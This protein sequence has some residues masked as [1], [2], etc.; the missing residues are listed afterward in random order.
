MVDKTTVVATDKGRTTLDTVVV[1]ATPQP[2]NTA[3]SVPP[4]ASKSGGMGPTNP[5]MWQILGGAVLGVIVL[6]ILA[7]IY[8]AI[9]RRSHSI[10]ANEERLEEQHQQRVMTNMM[11]NNSW[12]S[13]STDHF[14]VVRAD[15][16]NQAG[17]DNGLAELPGDL[18]EE[19]PASFNVG[20]GRPHTNTI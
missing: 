6:L 2:S 18:P 14:N 7:K 3:S 19:R 4:P 20:R 8:R 17:D 9:R 11:Y 5:L 12:T 1:Q 13:R 16:N 10:K 15:P